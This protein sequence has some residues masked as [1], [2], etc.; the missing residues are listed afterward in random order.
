MYFYSFYRNDFYNKIRLNV[1]HKFCQ[2]WLFINFNVRRMERKMVPRVKD[3]NP[4]G[5]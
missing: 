1:L 3:N 4:L 2:I 5:T